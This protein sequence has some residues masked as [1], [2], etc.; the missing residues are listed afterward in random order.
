MLSGTWSNLEEG[1]LNLPNLY[2]TE[3]SLD[4]KVYIAVLVITH[5]LLMP[6]ANNCSHVFGQRVVSACPF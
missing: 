4:G 5:I 6:K 3:V 2:G 1:A